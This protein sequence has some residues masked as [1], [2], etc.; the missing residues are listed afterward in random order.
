MILFEWD[1]SK[2]QTN[3]RKHGVSFERA[4][5]VFQDP[6][7]VMEQDRVEGGERRWQTLGLVEGIVILLVAHTIVEVGG[8]DLVRIISARRA[9]RQEQI[10]YEKNRQKHAG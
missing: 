10:R 4:K 6:Y 3:Q 7:A 9:N 8:D 5:F 1:E 2:A